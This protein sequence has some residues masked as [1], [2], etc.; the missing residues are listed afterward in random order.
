MLLKYLYFVKLSETIARLQVRKV[1]YSISD[2]EQMNT[3]NDMLMDET[4]PY[5]PEF[6]ISKG[7][8]ISNATTAL[9][10]DGTSGL[11]GIMAYID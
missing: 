11:D 5:L 8:K 2:R 6:G 4:L 3:F 10:T 9:E 1:K 7:T